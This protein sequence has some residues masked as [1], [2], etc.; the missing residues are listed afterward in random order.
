MQTTS[1]YVRVAWV[2]G[3][4]FFVVLGA[5]P[6]LSPHSFYDALAT[7]PPFNA[8]LLRDIGVFSLG[9]GAALLVALKWRDG[10]LVA[11]AGASAASVLHVI[12]HIVD[13]DK[14][15]KATDVPLLAVLAVV[16]VVGVVARAKEVKS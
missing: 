6:F 12:S 8:H 16:L 4:L 2:S 11:L 15:G 7:F 14:G 5:W 3:V 10:L 9:T 13:S 1:V